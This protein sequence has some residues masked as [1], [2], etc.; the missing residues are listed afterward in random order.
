MGR[1][2]YPRGCEEKSAAEDPGTALYEAEIHSRPHPIQHELLHSGTPNRTDRAGN[3]RDDRK[4]V[5]GLYSDRKV[6]LRKY[7]AGLDL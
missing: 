2:A 6:W 3:C 1:T 4:G 7:G 5:N